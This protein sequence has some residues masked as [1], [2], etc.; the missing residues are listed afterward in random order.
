MRNIISLQKFKHIYRIKSSI[1]A[2]NL[3]FKFH[4]FDEVEKISEVF[5]H[6]FIH[7]NRNNIYRKPFIRV[8]NVKVFKLVK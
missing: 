2:K 7:L 1:K 5:N 8:S 3:N 4:S 6:C